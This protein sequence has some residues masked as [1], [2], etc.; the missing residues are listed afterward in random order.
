MKLPGLFEQNGIEAGPGVIWL[1]KEF[2]L[3]ENQLQFGDGRLW[4]GRIVDADKVFLNGAFIGEVT[5]QYPP[6][7][8]TMYPPV[9]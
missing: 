5:Y 9:S 8:F 2:V 6:P 7:A 4:L 3:T 1:K